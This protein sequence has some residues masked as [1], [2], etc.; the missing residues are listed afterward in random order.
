MST[1]ADAANAT[2]EVLA[3]TFLLFFGVTP[4]PI[5]ETNHGITGALIGIGAGAL[6]SY[7]IDAGKER[8][9]YERETGMSFVVRPI[10][11]NAGKGVGV[12][13]RW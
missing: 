11:S 13:V 2:S 7:A 3:G 12:Q 1:W 6:L 8:T 5:K 10:V 9:L 4:E